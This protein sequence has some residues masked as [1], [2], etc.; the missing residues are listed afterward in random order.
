M[1]KIGFGV[2]L[3]VLQQDGKNEFKWGKCGNRN[4]L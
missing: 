3:Q 2:K 1:I 4:S